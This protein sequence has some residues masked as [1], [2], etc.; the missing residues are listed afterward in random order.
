MNYPALV[1][2]MICSMAALLVAGFLPF[3]TSDM[4]AGERPKVHVP[5][6]L[7]AGGLLVASAFCLRSSGPNPTQFMPA[8]YVSP[9]MMGGIALKWVLELLAQKKFVLQESI[10]ISA[11]L[12]APLF[13]MA[14]KAWMFP[15]SNGATDPI[16]WFFSGFF[17][18]AILGD[19]SR[20][21][22]KEVPVV[23]RREP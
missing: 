14:G 23:R 3:V 8:I 6:L 12:I 1:S 22:T 19:L 4:L 10:L 20:I 9:L 5:A 21:F 15:R 18:C 11:L 16:L 17:W 13:V 2:L 7:A